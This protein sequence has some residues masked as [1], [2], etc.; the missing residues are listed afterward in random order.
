MCLI[1]RSPVSECFALGSLRGQC[2]SRT[3]REDWVAISD[4]HTALCKSA[5][6]WIQMYVQGNI[7]KPLLCFPSHCFPPLLSFYYELTITPKVISAV[8]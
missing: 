3:W 7:L 4:M 8:F 5:L 2:S 6:D 1:R